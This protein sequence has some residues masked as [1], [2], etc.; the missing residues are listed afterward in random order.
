MAIKLTSDPRHDLE[1]LPSEILYSLARNQSAQHRVLALRLLVERGSR[2]ALQPEIVEGAR[3]LKLIDP[4]VI[5]TFADKLDLDA[6]IAVLR[7]EHA[8]DRTATE[9]RLAL[10]ERSL[11][12]R[13]V[14]WYH[15]IVLAG[16]R[17]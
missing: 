17:N 8:T 15:N 1:R 4:G 14:D 5:D 10:L 7:A 6:Q 16:H 13:L 9:Q 12:R 11:W 3:E 2:L